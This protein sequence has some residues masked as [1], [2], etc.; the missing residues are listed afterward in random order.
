VPQLAPHVP[1]VAE[2]APTQGRQHAPHLANAQYLA[3]LL[4]VSG[5]LISGLRDTVPAAGAAYLFVNLFHMP[6]F[7]ILAGYF[8]RNFSFS[9]GKARDLITKLALPYVLFEIAYSLLEWQINGRDH[10]TISLLDPSYLTWFLLALFAWRLSTP[11]WQQIRWP[12]AVAVVVSVLSY[13]GPLSSQLDMHRVFGMTPF[14]VLGLCLTPERLAYLR[15][16][17][18][19]IGGALVLAAG[20]AASF[21]AKD[22]MNDRWLHWRTTNADLGVSELTGSAVHLGL[23]LAGAILAAAFLAVVPR[24]KTWFTS[25]GTATIYA[26]LLHGFVVKLIQYKDLDTESAL[27]SLPGLLLLLV[28]GAALATILCSKPV[29]RTMRWAVEPNLRWAFT[30]LRRPGQPKQINP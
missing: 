23:L 1:D 9:K 6:V 18:V 5:N 29:V 21:V 17:W 3:I 27:Q 14:F 26:Y 15:L 10:L 13:T 4:V 16:T 8:S 20:L 12:L 25:L 7:I 22:H 11:V 28:A 19:R 2:T 24:R 30:H